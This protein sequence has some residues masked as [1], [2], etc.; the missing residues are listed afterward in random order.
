MKKTPR[1]ALLT[2]GSTIFLLSTA[3]PALAHNELISTAPEAGATVQAGQIPITLHFE[4]NPLHL[5][6]NQ[7]NLIAIANAETGEQFGPACAQI[8]GTD[9]TT[10]VD[11][12]K[13]GQ[14]KILWRT[15]SDDGH[16]ASGDY[17]ITVENT[18][19]YQTETPGNQCFDE[20][21]TPIKIADQV[22]LSTKTATGLSALQGLYIGIGFIVLGSVIS[23]IL[24][25]RKQDSSFDNYE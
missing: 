13:T 3:A 7:G 10:T 16:V 21:G 4:E 17:L 2:A 20:T 1:F 11:I 15:T 19:N 6:L 22:P 23:A 9:L 12:A 5:G 14:Y 25:R 24:I 8:V 18:T